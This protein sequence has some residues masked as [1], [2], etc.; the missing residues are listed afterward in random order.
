MF[1]LGVLS[2][3]FTSRVDVKLVHPVFTCQLFM[4]NTILVASCHTVPEH[5]G[6]LSSKIQQHIV[7]YKN[8]KDQNQDEQ[9]MNSENS[10][11][12]AV[13]QNWN[14]VSKAQ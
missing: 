7:E 12:K 10:V 11:R 2:A 8:K 14:F 3:E 13:C 6:C 1:F 9:I 4:A 5:S